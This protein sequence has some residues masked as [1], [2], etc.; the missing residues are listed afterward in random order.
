MKLTDIVDFWDKLYQPDGNGRW[1]HPDDAREFERSRHTF[2]LDYPVSP[3]VGDIINAP[4]I[5]LGLNAGYSEYMTPKEFEDPE[6]ITRY[7]QQVA[8]PSTS[9]WDVISD[10]YRTSNSWRFMLERNAVWIN[11][12]PYRSPNLSTEKGNKALAE[13]LAST[14]F[15]NRWM[16]EVVMPMAR[17]G[18]RLVAVKRTSL[19]TF[20]PSAGSTG[21]SRCKSFVGK[22]LDQSVIANIETFLDNRNK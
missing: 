8:N 14:R 15:H 20:L 18:Q 5:I 1:V 22:H 21:V 17:S 19:W 11:A 12:S 7:M 9:N 16:A 4:V 10:Y 13:Q 3:Y 6:I 2:N